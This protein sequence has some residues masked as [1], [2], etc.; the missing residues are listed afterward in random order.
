IYCPLPSFYY[1]QSLFKVS[2]SI[3]EPSQNKD[4]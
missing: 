4:A 3:L 2:S 1:E